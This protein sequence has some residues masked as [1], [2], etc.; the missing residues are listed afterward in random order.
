MACHDAAIEGQ[1]LG[2]QYQTRAEP[3]RIRPHT[4]SLPQFPVGAPGRR[5]LSG[6][7]AAHRLRQGATKWLRL[8]PT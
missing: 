5:D 2:F 8:A 7:S 3:I 1:D 4:E 6:S